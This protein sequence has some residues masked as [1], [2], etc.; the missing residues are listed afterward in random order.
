MQGQRCA[1]HGRHDV[2]H[3]TASHALAGVT[4]G[5]Q[6]HADRAKFHPLPGAVLRDD[7]R[8]DQ[9]TVEVVDAVAVAG[10]EQQP[11]FV[12]L[13][14]PSPVLGQIGAGGEIARSQTADGQRGE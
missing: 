8:G 14:G 4:L 3:Q 12:F 7:A 9:A 13:A 6:D 1:V 5:D 10:G 11:P 2:P